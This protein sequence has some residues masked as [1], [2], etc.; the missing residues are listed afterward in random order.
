[1]SRY[2]LSHCSVPLQ[3]EPLS[4]SLLQ[5]L[6]CPFV[7]TLSYI[8]S[9]HENFCHPH[10]LPCTLPLPACPADI[11]LRSSSPQILPTPCHVLAHPRLVQDACK[12]CRQWSVA[13][14]Q[15]PKVSDGILRV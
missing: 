2:V 15:V 8:P 12:V 4:P 3:T 6:F 14:C 11:L 5:A 1:M 9:L 13:L 10:R 7:N